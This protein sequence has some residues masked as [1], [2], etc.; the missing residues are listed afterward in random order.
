MIFAVRYDPYLLDHRWVF[1]TGGGLH[2]PS[3]MLA[4]LDIDLEY[5]F[6]TLRP[7][8]GDMPFC[9]R[10]WIFCHTTLC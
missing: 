4:G 7:G 10:F 5:T 8:H 2:R 9:R 1:D 6:Q 3:T